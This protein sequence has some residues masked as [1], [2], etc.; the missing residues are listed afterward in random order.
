LS[1][2]VLAL[3]LRRLGGYE[4]AM[5]SGFTHAGFTLQPL[6]QRKMELNDHCSPGLLNVRH[7][8]RLFDD[9]H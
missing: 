1:N 2:I 5:A 8:R 6:A 4:L 3:R 9:Q 7:Q